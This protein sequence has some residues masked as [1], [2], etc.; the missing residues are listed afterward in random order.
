[1]KLSRQL[2][3]LP[4]LALLFAV[5]CQKKAPPLPTQAKAPAELIP[6]ALPVEISEEA[7]P[8]PPPEESTPQPP[9]AEEPK[10]KA[11]AHHRRKPAQPPVATQSSATAPPTGGSNGT[12]TIAATHPPANPAAPPPETAIAADVS[13]AQLS[14]QKQITAQL[15]DETEKTVSGLNR[16]L[17]KDDQEI[18]VQIRSYVAQSRSATKDGDFERAY[19][20]ATKAH[21]LSAAL[22]KK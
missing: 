14:Q 6:S 10:P 1:M 20:L 8:P 2:V 18:I 3:A 16:T 9:P 11:S 15:L 7:P 21:L 5:G 22:I 13:S 4:L 12:T 19:N 17:S